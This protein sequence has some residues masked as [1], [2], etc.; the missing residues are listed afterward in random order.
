[1]RHSLLGYALGSAA[2]L[3]TAT[4]TAAV[5][6]NC[7]LRQRLSGT[8]HE[9][10]AA[11]VS[12]RRDPLT[13]LPN[14]LGV[15]GHLAVCA[16]SAD[17]IWVM[18]IDLDA[19][20]PINDTYGHGAGD[21]VLATVARRL[22]QID[23]A[24]AGRLGGDEFILIAEADTAD[25]AAQIAA[26]VISTVRRPITVRS[27]I[28]IRVTASVGWLQLRADGDSGDVLHTADTALYRAKA[29]GGNVA[30]AWNTDEPLR[31]VKTIRPVDRLRDAHPHR[32]H[33]EL[34]VVGA[35]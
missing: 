3:A 18:L 28:R 22:Q 10:N 20:K 13:G 16:A 12:A 15:D 35:R 4:A 6:G 25:E 32:V 19:F 21:V 30:V 7:R 26:D 23:G 27:N 24:L 1:M 31:T 9:L 5:I 14:R 11:L 17:P 34:G 8:R 2:A 29:A 33:L